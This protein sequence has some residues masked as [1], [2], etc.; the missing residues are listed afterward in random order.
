MHCVIGFIELQIRQA[1]IRDEWIQ[2]ACRSN[3]CGFNLGVNILQGLDIDNQ[4]VICDDLINE[5]EVLPLFKVILANLQDALNGLIVD[6]GLRTS[7]AIVDTWMLLF[8]LLA[9]SQ[10][11]KLLL[12]VL[13]NSGQKQLVILAVLLQL[14]PIL[15]V[16]VR[17]VKQIRDLHQG[18]RLSLV[19]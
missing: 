9:L 1:A 13:G 17:K 12:G 8:L 3:L 16:L 14:W 19:S 5:W 15:I 2:L 4:A 6:L 7:G 10:D 11:A 18:S